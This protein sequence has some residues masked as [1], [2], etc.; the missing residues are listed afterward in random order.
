VLAEYE[1]GKPAM[2][3]APYGKGRAIIVGSFLGS[4]YHHF[5]NPNNGKFF[6][7]LGEWLKIAKPVAV[8]STGPDVLVEARVLEGEGFKVLFGFNRGEKKTQAKFAVSVKGKEFEVKD[9]ETKNAVTQEYRN[10]HLLLE[11][12]LEPHEVWVVLIKAK[13]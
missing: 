11:K 13:I 1:N 9:L 8:T 3:Y 4:A 12:A 5:K 2:V 7:G 10:E 6:A